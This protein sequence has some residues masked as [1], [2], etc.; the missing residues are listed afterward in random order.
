MLR[1]APPYGAR[2]QP[3][4]VSLLQAETIAKAQTA[5]LSREPKEHRCRLA[6]R[7]LLEETD[8]QLTGS[9]GSAF[10]RL[11]HRSSIKPHFYLLLKQSLPN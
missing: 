8:I 1:L 2:G 9:C 6:V 3:T 4:T 10:H 5:A 11:M 7:F